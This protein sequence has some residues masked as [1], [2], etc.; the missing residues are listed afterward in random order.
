MV[1][2]KRQSDWKSSFSVNIRPS[3]LLSE[4]IE[5]LIDRV[6]EER[7]RVMIMLLSDIVERRTRI[8]TEGT[9]K[10]TQCLV[11]LGIEI[12]TNEFP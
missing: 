3:H 7:I 6:R 10:T 5:S 12:S 8:K 9:R 4:S 1:F 2:I 11:E